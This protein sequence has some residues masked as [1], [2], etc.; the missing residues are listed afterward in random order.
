VVIV[1]SSDRA[2]LAALVEADPALVIDLTGRL[3]AE[4]EELRGYQGVGW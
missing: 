3:G 2:A 1:S 4:V